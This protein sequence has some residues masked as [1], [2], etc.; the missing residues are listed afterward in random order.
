MRRNVF[1]LAVQGAMRKH[2][3][4]KAN[5]ALAARYRV[6]RARGNEDSSQ[7]ANAVK[8]SLSSRLKALLGFG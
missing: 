2:L 6:E 1:L 3:E 8:R 5:P 4:L 7:L